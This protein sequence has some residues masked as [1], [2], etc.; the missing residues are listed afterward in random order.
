M[1]DQDEKKSVKQKSE[2]QD[3]EDR[4]DVPARTGPILA[5]IDF[6]IDSR[7]ALGEALALAAALKKGVAVLHVIH[8]VIDVPDAKKRK[9]IEK[10][11]KKLKK[12]K[13]QNVMRT[14]TDMAEE[15]MAEFLETMREG[16]EDNPVMEEMDIIYAQGIPATQIMQEAETLQAHMIVMGGQGKSDI[17]KLLLGSISAKVAKKTKIPVLLVRT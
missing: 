2:E 14:L 9:K 1:A 17:K 3:T 7:A 5:A 12:K 15:A 8:D 11:I 16:N 4:R 10:K 13:N 6:S